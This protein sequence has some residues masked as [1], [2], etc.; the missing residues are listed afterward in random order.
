MSNGQ[1]S[2][3]NF[4]KHNLFTLITKDI[5]LRNCLFPSNNNIL[6]ELQKHILSL[7]LCDLSKS[8]QSPTN[9]VTIS[10]LTPQIHTLSSPYAC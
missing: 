5:R 8:Y 9:L 6:F 2:L 1:Q 4:F 7:L 10:F 3:E